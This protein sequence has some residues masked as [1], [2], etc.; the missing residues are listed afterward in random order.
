MERERER[1]GEGGRNKEKRTEEG[2]RGGEGGREEVG[3]VTKLI[4]QGL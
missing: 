4:V 2:R 1:C 3:L